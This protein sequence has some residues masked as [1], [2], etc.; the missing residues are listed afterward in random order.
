MEKKRKR[1]SGQKFMMMILVIPMIVIVTLYFFI[2]LNPVISQF[3]VRTDIVEYGTLEANIETLGVVIRNESPYPVPKAGHINWSVNKGEKVARQQKIA[4]VL[5]SES[6][7]SLIMEHEMIRIR[8]DLVE[9]GEDVESFSAETVNQLETR[10]K[11]LIADLTLNMKQNQFELAY[12]NRYILEET[13][14]Q[15]EILETSQELPEMNLKEL[16]DQKIEIEKKLDAFSNEIRSEKAGIFSIGSDGFENDLIA[17]EEETFEKQMEKVLELLEMKSS[18]ETDEQHYR[19]IS[20]HRWNFATKVPVE[21]E[22][23]Y[24][25]NK[26]VWVRDLHEDRMIR[27]IVSKIHEAPES[28][29]L[30]ILEFN[31][32]IEGWHENRMLNLELIPHRFEGLIVPRSSIV[33]QYGINGIFRVDVNGYAVFMPV[34]EIGRNDEVVV[35]KE[36]LVEVKPN[37]DPEGEAEMVETLRRYD[38]YIL[39][40]EDIQEGQRVR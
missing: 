38:R 33:E 3:R 20:E 21:Y 2:R 9:S 1:K 26:R 19:I 5:V 27:G 12:K 29:P 7:Q 17:L 34:E 23:M 16:K 35:L 14:R 6:D 32:P 18:I 13:A 10:I 22:S 15:L 4:D 30:M 39:N 24:E 28:P 31:V 11:N 8:M 37:N 25:V 36:G 40:P